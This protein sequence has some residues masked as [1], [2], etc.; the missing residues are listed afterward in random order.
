MFVKLLLYGVTAVH[1]FVS[2]VGIYRA[3]NTTCICIKTL[4]AMEDTGYCDS[5]YCGA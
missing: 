5:C 4:C 3:S 2:V 1:T